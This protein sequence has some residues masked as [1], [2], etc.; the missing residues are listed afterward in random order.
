MAGKKIKKQKSS[1]RKTYTKQRQTVS[2]KTKKKAKRTLKDLK[3]FAWLDKKTKKIK[4]SFWR[5]F[6]RW[7]LKYFLI[8][9]GLFMASFIFYLFLL[10]RDRFQK[11]K[12][13]I[14]ANPNNLE[15]RIELVEIYLNNNQFKEAEEELQAIQTG[16]FS[17]LESDQIE[18]LQKLLED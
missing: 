14:L 5:E 4:T 13:A 16:I 18:K 15:A 7:L 10:P 11:V 12:E 1:A 2:R 9:A 17:E 6:K 8:F 3:C